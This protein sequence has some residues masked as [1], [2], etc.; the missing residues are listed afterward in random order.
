MNALV[1]T[2]Y[3][4]LR[5]TLFFLPVFL[6]A[7]IVFYLYSQDSLSVAKYIDIQKGSFLLINSKLSQFPG[8]EYNLTQFGDALI[9]L[10][11]LT[12]FFVFAPKLWEALIVTSLV[13]CLYSGIL[14]K[15]FAIPRPAAVF[16]ITSFVIIGKTLTGHNSLPSGHSITVFSTLTVLLFAFTPQKFWYKILW[17][18]S[19]VIFGLF[20]VFTRVGVG[21]HYPIDVIVGSIIGYLAGLTGIFI[22]RKYKICNWISCKKYYPVFILLFLAFCIAVFDKIIHENLM[23]FYFTFFSLVFS[24][25]KIVRIYVQK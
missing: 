13:S 6:L 12:V 8:I 22:T 2:N 21:A 20:L 11:L 23:I 24:L 25:Y 7:I 14:K 4:R 19:I 15:I 3:S 17:I 9:F 10:S 1:I 18:L 5:F 16:D